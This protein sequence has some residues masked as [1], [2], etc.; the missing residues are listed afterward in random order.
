MS[1]TY[2]GS[3]R[4]VDCT[5]PYPAPAEHAARL[6]VDGDSWPEADL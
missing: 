5:T 6:E 3:C 4:C 1:G 2:N